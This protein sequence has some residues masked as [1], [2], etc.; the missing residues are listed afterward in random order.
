LLNGLCRPE[1]KHPPY[2]EV[3][4]L[5]LT[6]ALIV[7]RQFSNPQFASCVIDDS[8]LQ[9]SWVGQFS[10]A[11]REGVWLP[12]WLPESNGGYGSP[13]FVFYSP[14]VYY[15][16]AVVHWACGSIILSMKLVRGLGLFLSGVT[17]LAYTSRFLERKTALVAALV[18]V[19]I[20]FH[21][22]DISYWSLYAETW[23]WVWFPLILLFMDRIRSDQ[24]DAI[25]LLGLAVS[26]GGL[27][28]THLISA[29]M[30][31]FLIGAF[32]FACWLWKD[33]PICAARILWGALGG[34]ALSA[35]YLF[36]AIY[37]RKFIR[38]EYSTSLPEFD[39]HN[40]FLFFPS[41]DLMRAN[42]F[43]DK[44]IHILQV[45]S[46]L[47]AAWIVSGAVLTILRRSLL[48]LRREA[49]FQVA[50]AAFCLFFM[51]SPSSFIWEWVPGLAQ[52]QFSTRWLSIFSF[53]AAIVAG[54]GFQGEGRPGTGIKLVSFGHL[55][56]AFVA[57]LA[58]LLI[59]LGGC[60]LTEEHSRMAA[61][62][63]Y[64]A[65]EYNPKE[66]KLWR[67]RVIQPGEL[68]YSVV[69][70]KALVT[71]DRWSTHD[72]C[73][74]VKA[75]VPTRLRI[76]LLHYPGWTAS[77]DGRQ[78]PL[79]T[80]PESGAIMADVPSGFHRFCIRFED[81]WWRKAALGFSIL[82]AGGMLIWAIRQ[83]CK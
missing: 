58:S 44:T 17:M 40:T 47:Q 21:V 61:A 22:L 50:I 77:C 38:L 8:I 15:V 5:L 29:Y 69:D 12:R 65:P 24:N 16:T 46:V 80:D 23:A 34:L 63:I 33:P 48:G 43:Q 7:A 35:F 56:I 82:T 13:V 68:L 60:F 31:G 81:T 11:L 52:I 4:C 19:A 32:A 2:L 54:I 51:T 37:E 53:S 79:H 26:Y 76:R 27:V 18:Y 1:K 73:L 55:T 28:V 59:I 14:L 3:V 78:I 6:S 10:R 25:S 70:G 9:M 66:M 74:S 45:V 41:A 72:R 30:V 75:E 57:G 39:F 36:P 83:G 67:E 20:P 64:N 49:G 62:S 42:P 71:V